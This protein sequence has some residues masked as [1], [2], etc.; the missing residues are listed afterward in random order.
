ML[1]WKGRVASIAP[2]LFAC[3]ASII[4]ITAEISSART[5]STPETTPV[6][7]SADEDVI[8]TP[9]GSVIVTGLVESAIAIAEFAS[10]FINRGEISTTFSADSDVFGSGIRI[11]GNVNAPGHFENHGTVKTTAADTEDDLEIQIRGFW[12]NRNMTANLVNNGQITINANTG[13]YV[14]A[15][16]IAIEGDIQGNVTNTNIVTTRVKGNTSAAATGFNFSNSLNGNFEN[17]GTITVDVN[18]PDAVAGADG[19]YMGQQVVGTI[20]NTGTI[21]A[22]ATAQTNAAARGYQ[23]VGGLAGDFSNSGTII[24]NADSREKTAGAAGVRMNETVTGQLVN[25]GIITVTATGKNKVTVD[26]MHTGDTFDGIFQN[27]KS[28]TISANA[29]SSGNNAEASGVYI[30]DNADNTYGMGNTTTITNAGNI[31]TSANAEKMASA[32]GYRFSG[33][34]EDHFSNTGN[35]TVKAISRNENTGASDHTSN[36]A[37]NGINTDAD[38]MAMAMAKANGIGVNGAMTGNISGSGNI[39][40]TATGVNAATAN[41]LF[42]EQTLDGNFAN[43]GNITIQ[44]TST[45]STARANGFHAE[46]EMSGDISNSG[47]ITALANSAKTATANGLWLDKTLEGLLENTGTVSST[48]KSSGNRANANGI[49]IDEN[50][51]A[52]IANTGI[53]L[54]DAITNTNADTDTGATAN[55]DTSAFARGYNLGGD[56]NGDFSNSGIITATANG[57]TRAVANGMYLN[58]TLDGN[59]LNTG[60]I[61]VRAGV[62]EPTDV[63]DATDST[64]STVS[65]IHVGTHSGGTLGNIG[66]ISASGAGPASQV[67]GIHVGT[68]SGG[69][70]GNTG[71]IS[72]SGAGPVGQV[73]GIHVDTQSGGTLDNTGMISASGA[74]PEGQV[75]GI[76]VRN[77]QGR[78]SNS[79]TITVAASGGNKAN[80]YGIYVENHNGVISDVGRISAH[81]ENGKAYS[82]FLKD[83]DGSLNVDTLDTIRN[84]M[85]VGAHDVELDARGKSG[86][87]IFYFEDSAPDNGIFTKKVS[88]GRSV[89]FV[90]DEGGSNPVYAVIDPVD[91]LPSRD[92]IATYGDMI[93]GIASPG[94]LQSQDRIANVPVWIAQR[95]GLNRF[96]RFSSISTRTEKFTV[97]QDIKSDIQVH[98]GNIGVTGTTDNGALL[99]LGMGIFRAENNT[100]QTKAETGALYMNG[101]YGRNAGMLDLTAGLGLGLLSNRKT[102]QITGSGSAL[103]EYDSTLLTVHAGVKKALDINLDAEINGFGK[104]RY[105][106]QTDSAYMEQGSSINARVEKAVTEVVEATAGVEIEKQLPNKAGILSGEISG[107]FRTSLS[108]PG[109]RVRVLSTIRTLALVTP[110]FT[111]ANLRLGYKREMMPGMFLDFSA[112]RE[113]G[114]GA[115]GPGVRAMINWSF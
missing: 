30:D 11:S 35:I 48:A 37:S 29:T 52:N 67:S 83:G 15:D 62:T 70:L 114:T 77:S 102:R 112:E 46:L 85:H 44:A 98:D 63:T 50:I 76:H 17:S 43:S 34:L 21:N 87:T 78:I 104:I 38:T 2:S 92:V 84:T 108:D 89:W 59:L 49:L 82:V 3:S 109:A 110:D 32:T 69:T 22:R 26:G 51:T 12:F 45:A 68:Q 4:A 106:R 75:S 100:P 97:L 8:I 81:S 13:G 64:D 23:L 25:S 40:V 80:S 53:I 42:V 1:K 54:A 20:S 31:I 10:N 66:M 28:G 16:A 33:D 90:G 61:T 56:L 36:G 115:E 57:A 47:N 19:V 79:G 99:S 9:S 7:I 105:T 74:T 91:I 55:A 5:I 95:L 93:G 107:V 71:M 18:S 14:E 58:G 60:N 24:V 72:A 27:T 113:I 101:T 73:S 65:G 94:N 88:D 41:G 6:A 103:A 86:T 39:T 96:G 111:G